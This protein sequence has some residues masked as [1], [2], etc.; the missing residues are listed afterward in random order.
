MVRTTPPS[1]EERPAV[2]QQDGRLVTQ[3]KKRTR[4]G[5]LGCRKR[6]RKCMLIFTDR[7][8]RYH[9][10]IINISQATRP[11]PHAKVAVFVAS[12]ASGV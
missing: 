1:E 4:T 11:S 5:C 6:R 2:E 12:C 8:M 10:T 3:G 7:L 9:L